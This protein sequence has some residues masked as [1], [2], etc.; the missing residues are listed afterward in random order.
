MPELCFVTSR[1]G[2]AITSLEKNIIVKSNCV[3]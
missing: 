3:L 1:V 2:A